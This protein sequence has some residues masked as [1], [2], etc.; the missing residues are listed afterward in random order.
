MSFGLIIGTPLAGQVQIG[1]NVSIRQTETVRRNVAYSLE[2]K[3]IR[4]DKNRSCVS[5][6][7]V[8]VATGDSGESPYLGDVCNADSSSSEIAVS[9]SP[10]LSDRWTWIFKK[11]S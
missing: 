1:S 11:S 6:R 7:L 4:C 3:A 2:H 8:A 9:T 10:S 5:V